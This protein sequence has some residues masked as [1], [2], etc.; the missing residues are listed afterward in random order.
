M[1]IDNDGPAIQPD[2]YIGKRGAGNDSI[3][4]PLQTTPGLIAEQPKRA[5]AKW[6]LRGFDA[7]IEQRLQLLLCRS[8]GIGGA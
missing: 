2:E 6:Q 5:P 7:R 4:Q 1:V 3:G 8:E